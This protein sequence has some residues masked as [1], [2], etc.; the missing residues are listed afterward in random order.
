M[1]GSVLVLAALFAG[2]F[3]APSARTAEPHRQFRDCPHCPEL[4]RIPPGDFV[5]G[6]PP[7]EEEQEN[8]PESFR[9]RSVPQTRIAIASAFALGVYPVT[10]GE[11]ARFVAATGYQTGDRC[12]AYLRDADGWQWRETVGKGWRDP[13]FKQTDRDPVVCVNWHDAEAYA[14]WLAKITGHHYRL[15]SEAEGEYALR[16]GSQAARFW[17]DDREQACRYANVADLTM[18]DALDLP[19]DPAD[20]FDCRDGF[21]FTSPVG[22]FQPNPFGLYDIMGNVWQWLDDCWHPTLAGRPADARV[23][24][25]GA[26]CA[27]HTARGGS[28]Q[29]YPW[30]LRAGFRYR[31]ATDN[32][33]AKL[34]FR[35]ARDM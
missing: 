8:V 11:F 5:M 18:F 14:V 31:D 4:I 24:A 34:G 26:D 25:A 9:G 17:G 19:K 3:L 2:F 27:F 21:V 28:W 29:Y 30:S 20:N 6:V 22:S 15:P 1:R 32:R 13:G 23:W 16:G 10:R 12:F 35:V 33:N 7:G